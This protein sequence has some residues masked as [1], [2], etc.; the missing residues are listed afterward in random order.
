MARLPGPEKTE[1]RITIEGE[2][3]VLNKLV[4][5]CIDRSAEIREV[6]GIQEERG[7]DAEVEIKEPQ[8]V[9]GVVGKRV[10]YL[11]RLQSDARRVRDNLDAILNIAKHI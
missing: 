11:R 1:E 9:E 8:A 2:L 4:E 3:G 7:G 5:N 6:L 10:A